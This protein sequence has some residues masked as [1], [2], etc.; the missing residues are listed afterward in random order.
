MSEEFY[1]SRRGV[2]FFD[3]SL[4][5]LVKEVERLNQVLERIAT[6]LEARPAKGKNA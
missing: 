2:T 1:R 5:A 3:H 4:P 6:A